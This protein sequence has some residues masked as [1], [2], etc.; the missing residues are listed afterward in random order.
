MR[1]EMIAHFI[2]AAGVLC[3]MLGLLAV[4]DQA[5]E[6]VYGWLGVTL[7]IQAA[8]GRDATLRSPPEP[9]E[10][11]GEGETKPAVSV[12]P[13]A[14]FLTMAFVPVIAMLHAGFLDG[15]TGVAV[16]ALIMLV[17]LYRLAFIVQPPEYEA[18]FV[19]LPATWG[20]IGFYLH[21]L[22]ATPLA[23]VLAIGLGIVLGLAPLNWP[24][25]LHSERWPLL[26]VGMVVMWFATAAYALFHGFQAMPSIT[27]AILLGIAAYGLLLTALMARVTVPPATSG[28]KP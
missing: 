27:K 15:L 1:R 17:A 6:Q 19:G 7:M 14:N 5:W 9:L 11:H 24:N 20:V 26:T 21:A 3:A 12:S 16:A 2:G 18:R 10:L 8:A 22:D 13:I 4:F 28:P 23:A 25:P